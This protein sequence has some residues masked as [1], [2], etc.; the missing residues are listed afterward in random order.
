M[1]RTK[2]VVCYSGGH[3]SA[4]VAIEVSRRYGTENL[5]LLNHDIHKRVEN[6]DIKR[7]KREVA[8]YLHVP[9]TYANM[10]GWEKKD[11]FDVVMD[12]NAFKVGVGSAICS[13]HLKVKPFM[14][15]LAEHFPQKNC[16]IY[17]GFDASET[18]RIVRRARLLTNEGYRSVYPLA[19]WPRTITDTMQIGITPPMTYGTF[20]HANCTGCLKAGKHHWYVVYCKRPDI[21]KRASMAEEYI[22]YSLFRDEWL[23]ELGVRFEQM[24]K[25]GVPADENIPQQEF[26]ARARK[27]VACMVAD[28]SRVLPCECAF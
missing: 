1:S 3:S 2:H 19:Q 22:G 26:W 23:S 8:E 17:Y 21:W 25:A 16:I 10:E 12:A 14:E 27:V 9:I 24:K 7:F 15:F 4:I 20:K 5:I 13:Y 11:Q 18:E 6:K 28:D